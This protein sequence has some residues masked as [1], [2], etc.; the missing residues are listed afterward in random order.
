TGSFVRTYHISAAS[1]QVSAL[2]T[3]S[4]SYGYGYDA[5]GNM[6]SETTS[7]HFEWNHAGQLA[8]FR[9]QAAPTSEPSVYAEYRYDSAGQRVLKL[10]R[11]HG[12]QLAVT[13]Y[14]DGLF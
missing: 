13:T 3:G 7:R 12:G 2:A 6:L 14:I 1:N 5:S 11:K 10:V 4:T 9:T 8:T